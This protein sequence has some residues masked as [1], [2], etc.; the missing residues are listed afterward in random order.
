MVKG[1]E[2]VIGANHHRPVWADP[3]FVPIKLLL[4]LLCSP[5]VELEVGEPCILHVNCPGSGD[6]VRITVT[7][8]DANHC[9]G[10]AMFL[11][12]GFFGSVLYTGDFRSGMEHA[13]SPVA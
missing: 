6:L 8:F 7:V 2:R 1:S 4:L 11:F 12:E 10:A 13:V 9:P 3:C 5:Q